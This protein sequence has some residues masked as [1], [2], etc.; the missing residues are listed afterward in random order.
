VTVLNKTDA[1]DADELAEKRAELEAES[2]G[3]VMAMSGV[4]REGVTDV[5][6]SLR[7]LVDTDRA[8]VEEAKTGGWTP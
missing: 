2:G 3:A 6:R 5:L 8:P 7:A 4:S 1:L